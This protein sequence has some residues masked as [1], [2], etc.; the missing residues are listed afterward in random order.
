MFKYVNGYF[1]GFLFMFFI[2]WNFLKNNL[3]KYMLLI[4]IEILMIRKLWFV[5]NDRMFAVD[6]YSDVG[7]CG[8]SGLVK[9]A[10][11]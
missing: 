11:L 1:F 6:I 5:Y 7:E 4:F 10:G 9:E 2:I 3:R 8:V